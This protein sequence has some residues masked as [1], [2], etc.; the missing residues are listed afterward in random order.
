MSAD[1]EWGVNTAELR[2][3]A[4]QKSRVFNVL[5]GNMAKQGLNGVGPTPVA[6]NPG[7]SLNRA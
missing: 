3:D 7:R 2:N 4:S 5:C 1:D 6:I